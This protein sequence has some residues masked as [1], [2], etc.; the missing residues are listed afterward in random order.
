MGL[1]SLVGVLFA[2]ALASSETPLPKQVPITQAELFPAR[3]FLVMATNV[4]SNSESYRIV[5]VFVGPRTLVRR[6]FSAKVSNLGWRNPFTINTNAVRQSQ[7][8]DKTLIVPIGQVDSTD[9]LFYPPPVMKAVPAEDGDTFERR[10]M[11]CFYPTSFAN[12]ARYPAALQIASDMEAIY[13]ESDEGRFK[14]IDRL[15]RS[16]D[17]ERSVTALNQLAS[18]VTAPR[19]TE[20]LMNLTHEPSLPIATQII[21]WSHLRV[22]KKDWVGSPGEREL[23]N[24][25]FAGR[26]DEDPSDATRPWLFR[27]ESTVLSSLRTIG[28]GVR[29]EAFKTACERQLELAIKGL[30]NPRRSDM[31]KKGILLELKTLAGYFSKPREKSEGFAFL[32]EVIKSKSPW[33]ERL[34]AAQLLALLTPLDDDQKR[35]I[36]ALAD[37]YE[38]NMLGR[39]LRARLAED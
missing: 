18:N 6:T 35:R 14:A 26:W 39:E 28:L 32:F 20:Y 30:A 21:L 33:D 5:H 3:V 38:L 36:R 7:G 37:S 25:W 24:H 15:I 29:P 11:T 19:I 2:L 31:F 23:V 17:A 12:D 34:A 4:P 16:K 27:T 13:G 10:A 1:A 8:D 9:M 22:R